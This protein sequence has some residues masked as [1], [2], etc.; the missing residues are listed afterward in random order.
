MESGKLMNACG[1]LVVVGIACAGSRAMAADAV[2]GSFD[3]RAYGAVG[4]GKTIDTKAI[5]AAIDAAAAAGGGTVYF[6][7]GTYPSYSIHLKSN[8]TL[9]LDQGATLLAAGPTG[10]GQRGRGGRGGAGRGGPGGGPGGPGG[11]RGG[12]G[13]RGGRGGGRGPTT[14]PWKEGDGAMIEVPGLPFLAAP[15]APPGAVEGAG[16]AAPA[17]GP[18]PEFDAPEANPFSAYQDFGHSH[19]HNSLM[20]GEN[21]QNITIAGPGMID[22][23][24]LST[25]AGANTPAGVGNKA[26][27]LKLCRNVTIR[28]VSF[29][30]GGHFCI[31][32]N[33]VDNFTIDNAKFD[34]NRDSMD[35]VSCKN[36]RISN[37]YVNSPIDDGICLKA[38]YA[39]GQA[40]DCE[41]ITITNCQVSGYRTGTLLDGTFDRSVQQAPDRDGPTGRIKFGTESTG[42]FKN[43]SIS[44]C[45]FD[46]CRGLAIES[47]DGGV[48]EDVSVTNLTMRD[49]F[50][51]P[52]Y[53]RLGDRRRG[54]AGKTPIAQI[55]RI[56]ISNVTASGVDSRYP[57]L[58]SGFPEHPVEDVRISN[59]RIS[60]KG[61]GTAEEAQNK[62]PERENQ[63]YP[64]PSRLGV[65]P[66]SA[67]FIRHAERVEL[68]HINVSFEKPDARPAV[69]LDDVADVGF[70]AVNIER[71]EGVPL[72]SLNK[73]RGFAA[74]G[75]R[76]VADTVQ[77]EV[78]KGV[79]EK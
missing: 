51:P 4:N 37:C 31:L 6:R 36:V 44:N 65:L 64:E 43:I 63:N 16:A 10:G 20:W 40:R 8:I 18:M 23:N 15:A 24:G 17:T 78:E 11:L 9:Y 69:V 3:V 73:V 54:P 55:R 39:L 29:Y 72:F 32:A 22:G 7:A 74:Q 25:N 12:P 26:L 79:I 21:L 71:F 59:V 52:I 57:C 42:G 19:F 53:I 27:A 5:N 48:I 33:A 68:D 35:I 56:T 34:T 49:I 41:N 58:I 62:V 61:G 38:D 66:A 45:V 70:Q 13:G 2:A 50:N 30:R 1:L 60:Y 75:V 14:G 67:F 76:S 77:G 46:H 47:V 28:D